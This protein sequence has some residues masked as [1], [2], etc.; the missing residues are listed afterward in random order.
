[1]ELWTYRNQLAADV[2]GTLAS[3]RSLGFTDI[4]TAS[5]YG[6]SASEFHQLLESVGLTCGSIIVNYDKLKSDLPG[7]IADARTLGVK[8]VI[9]AGF[10]HQNLLTAEAVRRA[11]ADFNTWGA[12]LKKQGLQFGYH[13]HGFE[14]VPSG[15]GNL[16]AMLLAE[17]HEPVTYEL[18]TYH[19]LQGG[20][21][22]VKYL[23]QYPN[24][25]LLVH[26]KDMAKGTPTG[27]SLAESEVGDSSVVLGKGIMDWAA[28][29]AAAKKAGVKVYYIEDESPAAPAQVPESITYLKSLKLW[30]S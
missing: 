9:T 16:F 13:P 5:F 2:P 25:F 15:A 21:D 4:E 27:T 30:K 29:F 6:R 3:I 1:M 20:G 12:S 28:F 18:D 19:M 14:V 24:R 26:L 23:E 17:T 11:A 7:V 10:P 22:P 8:Y